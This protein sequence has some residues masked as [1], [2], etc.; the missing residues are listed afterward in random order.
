MT[1]VSKEAGS[2][3]LKIGDVFRRDLLVQLTHQEIAAKAKEMAEA[4][5][6]LTRLEEEKKRVAKEYSDKIA[7]LKAKV[8]HLAPVIESGI[9]ERPVE[10]QWEQHLGTM[11]QV[12]RRL[13]TDEVLEE[14]RKALSPDAL[15]QA[16]V[17]FG[18]DGG[19]TD[20]PA[21]LRPRPSRAAPPPKAEEAPRTTA[22]FRRAPANAN[23]GVHQCEGEHEFGP[24][25][26]EGWKS[27]RKCPIDTRPV[28]PPAEEPDMGE[29]LAALEQ[30]EVV[31]APKA[32][33]VRW[34]LSSGPEAWQL[35][36]EGDNIFLHSPDMPGAPTRPYGP[37]GWVPT[38]SEHERIAPWAHAKGW[39]E[40]PVGVLATAA[41][42]LA[43]R[44]EGMPAFRT[45]AEVRAEFAAQRAAAVRESEAEEEIPFGHQRM[46]IREAD[47]SAITTDLRVVADLEH[48]RKTSQEN[49]DPKKPDPLTPTADEIH[50]EPG[51]L[52]PLDEA[53]LVALLAGPLTTDQLRSKTRNHKP[54]GTMKRLQLRGLVLEVESAPGSY[55]LT[56]SARALAEGLKSAREE[57]GK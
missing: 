33:E 21:E 34:P 14:S 57:A 31:P 55:A 47:S 36:L 10:V 3:V 44:P 49:D 20:E 43:N 46:G 16:Q 29:S 40:V 25:D 50:A 52:T 45:M 53:A 39:G 19:G 26:A 13:D 32:V 23:R 18:F 27:C 24:A 5:I 30:L 42:L 38:N 6:E 2:D 8:A 17:N 9:E 15:E 22:D 54:G 7:P 28:A 41:E 37:A 11:S 56:T 51:K 4:Q 35:A 12:L 1:K 48:A